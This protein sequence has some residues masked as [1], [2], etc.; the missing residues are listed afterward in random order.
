[1]T[2]IE[3][4]RI[5][6]ISAGLVSPIMVYVGFLNIDFQCTNIDNRYEVEL[7][8]GYNFTEFSSNYCDI[9]V[10][11]FLYFAYNYWHKQRK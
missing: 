5:M 1:M 6:E 10:Y 9:T 2:K 7:N 8:T 4:N 11:M 3:T